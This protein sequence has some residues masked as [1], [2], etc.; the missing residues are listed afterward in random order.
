MSVGAWVLL[1]AIAYLAISSMV[2][3]AL[4]NAREQQTRPMPPVERV[5]RDRPLDITPALRRKR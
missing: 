1:A 3:T 4:R 2:G 5:D